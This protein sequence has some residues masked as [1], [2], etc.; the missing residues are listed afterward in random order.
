[1]TENN[2]VLFSCLPNW[3]F[4]LKYEFL[5][6]HVQAITVSFSRCQNLYPCLLVSYRLVVVVSSHMYSY[7]TDCRGHKY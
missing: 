5:F 3:S 7:I 4:I 6:L 1:M 2:N